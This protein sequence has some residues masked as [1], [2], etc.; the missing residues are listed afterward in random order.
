M[1]I[2]LVF[3]VIAGIA[4]LVFTVWFMRWL[5]INYPKSY[6]DPAMAGIGGAAAFLVL[7]SQQLA[8]PAPYHVLAA[9]VPICIIVSFMSAG[10]LA[11][12]LTYAGVSLTVLLLLAVATY[13]AGLKNWVM[14]SGAS[15]VFFV[16]WVILF[17]WRYVHKSN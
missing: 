11:S 6:D 15:A 1:D 4:F 12:R 17:R 7:G 13:C 8:L 16:L 3:I 5:K 2:F 10:M 14:Y 9:A